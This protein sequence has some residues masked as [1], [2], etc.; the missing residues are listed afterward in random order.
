MLRLQLGAYVNETFQ[1]REGFAP[2]LFP[3]EV[4]VYMG[5]Y[6]KPHTV[7]GTSIEYIGSPYQ[8]EPAVERHTMGMHSLSMFFCTSCMDR[9]TSHAGSHDDMNAAWHATAQSLWAHVGGMA[10]QYLGVRPVR[11]STCWCW[12][13]AGGGQT[14]SS[15][16]SARASMS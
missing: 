12:T 9:H 6:H 3:E 4:P 13:A 8:G 15:W 16:I 1:A 11:G 5:H 2:D 7:Q 10:L 14:R